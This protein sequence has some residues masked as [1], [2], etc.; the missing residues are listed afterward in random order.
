MSTF[1]Q[2]FPF[3]VQSIKDL[4]LSKEWADRDEIVDYMLNHLAV[5]DHFKTDSK[6]GDLWRVSN[7]VDW[8]SAEITDESKSVEQYIKD[9]ERKRVKRRDGKGKM[10]SIWAYRFTTMRTT[11]GVEEP[12]GA[13]EISE[14]DAKKYP[15]G[16]TRKVVVN[17]YERDRRARKKCIEYYGFD[18]KVCGSNLENIYGEIGRNFIHVHHRIELS[19]VK[20]G[21][22]V[23]PID[24]LIP[25]CPN[26]HAM[27]HK[28][29][30]AYTIGELKVILK[31]ERNKG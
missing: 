27:L 11:E 10:R 16:M 13:E 12:Q 14:L 28:K 15:E 3:V 26:C 9:I 29:N 30:P 21:Y 24:D 6:K 19:N 7:M 1:E 4:N 25:V 18:C 5:L 22:E 2:I 20:I 23:N 31:K 8:F 17:R